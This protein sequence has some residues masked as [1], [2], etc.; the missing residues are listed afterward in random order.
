MALTLSLLAPRDGAVRVPADA[1]IVVSVSAPA[2]VIADVSVK[3]DGVE[4]YRYDGAATFVY[5]IVSGS[6]TV[7]PA[8][9]T[10]TVRARRRF[11]PGARVAVSVKSSTNLTASTTA[12]FGFTV[13][14]PRA[15]DRAA[16]RVDSEFPHRALELMRQAA[17]GAAVSGGPAL[18]ALVH[19]VK[20]SQL[21]SLLP[22]R[23]A[24]SA[25]SSGALPITRLADA[26]SGVSMLFSLASEEL[27]GLG[28]GPEIVDALPR[29]L[30]ADYP[31]E[32]AA[33]LALTVLLAADRLT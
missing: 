4:V 29:G 17:V 11:D 8:A 33:G 30:S 1:V 5:P 24:S 12:E 14:L 28:V 16:S 21:A 3:I 9:Q 25:E 23:Y 27:L 13:E 18:G 19:R 31:Q 6:A 22:A 15:D 2:E 7:A 10:V 32:R 20:A 26:A